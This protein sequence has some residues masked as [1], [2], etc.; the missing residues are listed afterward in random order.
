[1]REVQGNREHDRSNP[2]IVRSF[3][4]QKEDN[5]IV[6]QL[7]M[8]KFSQAWRIWQKKLWIILFKNEPKVQNSEIKH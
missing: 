8:E 7:Y 1:M 3:R 5:A 4:Q 2:A 6:W